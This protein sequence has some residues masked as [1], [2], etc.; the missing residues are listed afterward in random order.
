MT[1][2]G[3]D[4][5]GDAAENK[6][7][8]P[9]PWAASQQEQQPDP[10]A[11]PQQDQQPSSGQP[12]QGAQSPTGPQDPWAAPQQGQQPG[13]GQQ[14]PGQGQ[15][16]YG[17]QSPGQQPP[18]YGQP[19]PGQGTSPYGQQPPG[20]GQ[21]P[22]AQQPY[23]QGGYAAAPA[24]PYGYNQSPMPGAGAPAHMGR[25]FLALLID[26]IILGIVNAILRA[27]VGNTGS[28]LSLLID[29]AY[30]GY[31]IGVRQQTVG[32]MALG[33]KVIDAGTGGAI[34]VG[35]GLLRYLVQLLTGLLCLVGY[36]SPF[37]DGTKRYQGWHDK[38]ARDFVISAK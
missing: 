12:S 4:P 27:A 25:R 36:F 5:N 3:Q 32:M 29:F 30:F 33:I 20:Y 35:R 34:G 10:W 17:Q 28:L 9:D 2:W 22:Y 8:Q 38:A 26:G 37:F 1:Q 23:G 13:Y 19:P 15:P 14:P 7:S 21:Q 18:G 24:A 16:P 11:V 6:P 31:L